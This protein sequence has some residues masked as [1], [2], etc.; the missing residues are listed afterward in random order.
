M[1]PTVKWRIRKE[2]DLGHVDGENGKEENVPGGK[3]IT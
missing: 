1:I 2:K 3:F